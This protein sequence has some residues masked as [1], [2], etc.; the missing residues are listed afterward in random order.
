MLKHY[1]QKYKEIIRY[2]IVGGMTT[3]VSL[4]TY[5]LC[6]FTFLDANQP[7]ELQIAN[8]LSW[9]AAVT[10][11]Y[12]ASRVYV[13]ESKNE[14]ILKEA[15]SFYLAR[16]STLLIDMFSMFLMVTV[17]HMND[18]IAKILVQFIVMVLNYVFSKIFVFRKKDS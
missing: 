10:F 17:L 14:H 9:I 16:I 18:R 5:Y 6:V 11:S 8:I 1:Y 15:I 2:V 7:V 12:F 3:V 4:G 13:F